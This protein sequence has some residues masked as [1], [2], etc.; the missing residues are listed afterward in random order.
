MRAHRHC[1]QQLAL[2]S[3]AGH[4]SEAGRVFYAQPQ[5]PVLHAHHPELIAQTAINTTASAAL[6]V[7]PCT[8]LAL[9]DTLLRPD[10]AH[11][12]NLP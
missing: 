12:S 2:R 3:P 11:S 9:L 5:Q 8:W 7:W 4:A 10:S 6:Q 1:C